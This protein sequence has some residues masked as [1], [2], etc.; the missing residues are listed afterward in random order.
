MAVSLKV[1]VVALHWDLHGRVTWIQY[2]TTGMDTPV[3]FSLSKSVQTVLC[4][5]ENVKP[6]K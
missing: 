2:Q 4:L 6:I 3:R 5:K 1:R